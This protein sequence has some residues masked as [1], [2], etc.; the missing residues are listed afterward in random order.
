MASLPGKEIIRGQ[1]AL[2][3]QQHTAER[4]QKQRKK[5]QQNIT[6]KSRK[7]S[8]PGTS[9]FQLSTPISPLLPTS[10]PQ[11]ITSGLA[12]SQK[13]TRRYRQSIALKEKCSLISIRSTASERTT[14]MS[15][16]GTSSFQLSTPISPL[17]R[18]PVPQMMIIS[19][20]APSQKE[21]RRYRQPSV[22]KEKIESNLY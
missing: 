20:L 2:E 19:G 12:S 1:K 14:E 18:T 4:R 6:E 8:Y 13:E 7:I 11:M 5:E 3:L 17:L 9:S 10:V 21:T 15:Y 16:P 22:L